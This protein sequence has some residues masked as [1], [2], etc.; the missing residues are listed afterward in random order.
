MNCFAAVREFASAALGE[1]SF[2]CYGEVCEGFEGVDGD[3]V[4]C[5]AVMHNL[6]EFVSVGKGGCNE[7]EVV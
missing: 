7:E 6:H 5:I 2:D 1:W 4:G 3:A